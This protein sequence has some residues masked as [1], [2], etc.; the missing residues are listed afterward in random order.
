MV[1]ICLC[2]CTYDVKACVVQLGPSIS[3]YQPTVVLTSWAPSACSIHH[4]KALR[5]D[6]LSMVILRNISSNSSLCLYMWS[7]PCTHAVQLRNIHT[8][9]HVLDEI[10]LQ[11]SHFADSCPFLTMSSTG[12]IIIDRRFF[13][14]GGFHNDPPWNMRN[15]SVLHVSG[16]SPCT[17]Q[18]VDS[19]TKAQR[20]ERLRAHRGLKLTERLELRVLRS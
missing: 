4:T 5:T 13:R 1:E 19:G 15:S 12:G 7:S 3:Q 17:G 10:T 16:E 2:K 18:E 11:P 8:Y 9:N 20:W 14:G 6:F